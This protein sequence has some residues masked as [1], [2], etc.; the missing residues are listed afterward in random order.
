MRKIKRA[1][2]I[3]RISTETSRRNAALGHQALLKHGEGRAGKETAEYKVWKGMRRRCNDPKH[4]NYREYGVR[5]IR[6]CAAWDDYAQFLADMGRRPTPKHTI[7][8]VD[9]NGNYEPRNCVWATRDA[10]ANNARSNRTYTLDG[11]TLNIAQWAKRSGV[12][13]PALLYRLDRG[14]PVV[15]AIDPTRILR[16]AAT[17]KN[18]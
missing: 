4:K 9:N 5:G 14:V 8:R 12:A 6:V 13:Y 1:Y 18:P 11:L 17:R 15:R 16:T 10:Q 2:T 7:E 3:S